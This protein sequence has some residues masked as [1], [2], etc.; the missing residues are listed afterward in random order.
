MKINNKVKLFLVIMISFYASCSKQFTY[1]YAFGTI[2]VLNK[3]VNRQVFVKYDN[4]F[5]EINGENVKEYIL[6]GYKLD[7]NNHSYAYEC[8]NC[9]EN[10]QIVAKSLGGYCVSN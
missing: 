7:T 1:C 4:Q 6:Q 2:Y 10:A 9:S 3:G 8:L 5:N